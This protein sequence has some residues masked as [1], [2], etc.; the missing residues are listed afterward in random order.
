MSHA[1]IRGE[2]KRRHEVDLGIVEVTV[3]THSST[4][5][6][7]F[8]LDT[9][10]PRRPPHNVAIVRLPRH[11]FR[12]AMA[13]SR[14]QQ[15]GRRQPLKGGDPWNLHVD[16]RRIGRVADG[17][18]G[19][20]Q[21]PR[22]ASCRHSKPNAASGR[23]K[24]FSTNAVGQINDSLGNAQLVQKA[25]CSTWSGLGSDKLTEIAFLNAL[26]FSCLSTRGAIGDLNG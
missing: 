10:E 25:F 9:D 17:C 22:W 5:A 23:C 8:K 13:T 26:R 6:F 24:P 18:Y 3:S 12:K 16:Y 4:E 2:Q 7:N 20:D 21:R 11:I 19:L 15:I 14:T 1:I